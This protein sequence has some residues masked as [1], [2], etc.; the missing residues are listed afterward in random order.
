M[1]NTN[2]VTI[3]GR[4]TKEVEEKEKCVRF[5][6]AVDR[7]LKKEDKDAGK[8]AADFISCVAFGATAD[9]IK[10]YARKGNRV[11]VGGRI[12][13]G[14]YDNKDGQKV[15]T[16]DVVAEDCTIIDWPEKDGQ[17]APS[18]QAP[19]Q[20]PAA[21]A[22]PQGYAQPQIQPA[23]V[24]Q[25]YAPQ[26]YQQ[27]MQQ[28]PQGYAQPQMQPAPTAQNMMNVQGG[29]WNMPSTGEPQFK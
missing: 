11:L 13:T 19:A 10:K 27:P 14:S 8:Q 3:M 16:T 1:S 25:G 15:Y 5:T 4:L 2:N 24:P 9:F 29:V 20:A 6:V 26:G 17:A 22:V 28:M 12:Q 18:Q 21:Q 23:P 7:K